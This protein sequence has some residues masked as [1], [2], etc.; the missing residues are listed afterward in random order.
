VAVVNEAASELAER[1]RHAADVRRA[2]RDLQ[3]LKVPRV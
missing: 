3:Q 1:R 2:I